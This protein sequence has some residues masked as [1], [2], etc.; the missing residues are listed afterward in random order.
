VQIT[1]QLNVPWVNDRRLTSSLY[2]HSNQL[3]IVKDAPDISLSPVS[4]QNTKTCNKQ[5]TVKIGLLI[6][7]SLFLPE[8]Y[9][10]PNKFFPFHGTRR[11]SME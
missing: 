9:Q 2:S 1:G 6:P 7:W 4:F 3:F 11:F 5:V 10:L 8:A